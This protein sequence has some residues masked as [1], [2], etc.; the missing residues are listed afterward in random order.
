M[1]EIQNG[2]LL[3][4]LLSKGVSHVFYNGNKLRI[5]QNRIGLLP[6]EPMILIIDNSKR[7]GIT[8]SIPSKNIDMFILSDVE[9][10]YNGYDIDTINIKYGMLFHRSSTKFVII[11]HR[12]LVATTPISINIE[13][14][15]NISLLI[16]NEDVGKTSL[17]DWLSGIT[18]DLLQ[19]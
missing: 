4:Y 15:E 8:L 14:V 1:T 11:S 16:E 5:F 9:S 6:V 12:S 19:F 2:N 10:L 18:T 3:S 17:H 13:H 7:D